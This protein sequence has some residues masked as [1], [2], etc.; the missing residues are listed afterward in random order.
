MTSNS[1]THP[2]SK[3]A[4]HPS[5]LNT[6]IN[7]AKPEA[8]IVLKSTYTDSLELNPSRIAVDELKLVGSRC[9]DVEA[10]V[11]LLADGSIEVE[12]LIDEVYSLRDAKTA[13]DH[14]SQPDALKIQIDPTR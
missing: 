8:T 9:G 13:F 3:P 12:D 1:N 10:A 7:A 11:K 5:G 4:G 14:A 2:S 6:A